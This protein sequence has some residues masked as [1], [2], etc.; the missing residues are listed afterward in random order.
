MVVVSIICS[1]RSGVPSCLRADQVRLTASV[2][3]C[4]FFTLYRLHPL[5]HT[6]PGLKTSLTDHAQR[7]LPEDGHKAYNLVHGFLRRASCAVVAAGRG[8]PIGSHQHAH[9]RGRAGAAGTPS[10][11]S[12]PAATAQVCPAGG[13]FSPDAMSCLETSPRPT[14]CTVRIITAHVCQDQMHCW[15]FA[16]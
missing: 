14:V 2:V 1:D 7:L 12:Q 13:G 15:N 16:L 5:V 11:A 9:Q 10:P 3:L 4:F 8:Q 6:R